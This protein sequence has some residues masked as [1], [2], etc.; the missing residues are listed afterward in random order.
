MKKVLSILF[1]ACLAT[2]STE[3]FANGSDTTQ[4]VMNQVSET[5]IKPE[6]LPQPVQTA[7]KGADYA[8]WTVASAYLVKSGDAETYKVEVVNDSGKKWLVF[9]K[10]GQ[11]VK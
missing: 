6:E 7:L 3:T 10:E 1:V 4:V 9:T 8:G 2:V 5:P 11:L